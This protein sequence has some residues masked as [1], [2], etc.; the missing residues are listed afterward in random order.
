VRQEA[1]DRLITAALDALSI[2]DGE[3]FG[4]LVTDDVVIE[5]ARRTRSG[6]GE[7]RDWAAKRYDH[8]DRRYRITKLDHHEHATV[9]D[10]CVE[11]LWRGEEAVADSSPVTFHFVLAGDRIARIELH[12]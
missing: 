3:A 4:A 1:A 5:T 6:V 2:A 9:V 12:D 7:A 8:L 10:A 11:Y